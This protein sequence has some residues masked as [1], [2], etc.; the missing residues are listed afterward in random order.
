MSFG[1]CR[2]RVLPLALP[3]VLS[4]ALPLVLPLLTPLVLP[5]PAPLVLPLPTPL[6]LPLPP[7]LLFLPIPRVSAEKTSSIDGNNE[8]RLD[9]GV[10]R[11][12][13][14]D[15]SNMSE[16]SPPISPTLP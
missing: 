12:E 15:L 3:L 2:T 1:I 7:L 8:E 14:F 16:I 13:D 5:L 4:V 9:L 6:V 11:I 10:W